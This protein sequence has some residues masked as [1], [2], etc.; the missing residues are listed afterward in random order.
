MSRSD[1]YLRPDSPVL[2]NKA[3]ETSFEALEA[4]KLKYL[5]L[6]LA[7]R[8]ADLI[9]IGKE[10]NYS[11]EHLVE[12]HTALNKGL[13]DFAGKTRDYPVEKKFEHSEHYLA[14]EM[15][16]PVLND[17]YNRLVTHDWFEDR[18]L[19]DQKRYT[20]QFA[21]IMSRTYSELLRA[22]P[23]EA[24]NEL[25]I[26]VFIDQMATD[27]GFDLDWNEI[28]NAAEFKSTSPEAMMKE[29]R[30]EA[31][32]GDTIRLNQ[33]FKHIATPVDYRVN[34][35]LDRSHQKSLM[36]LAQGLRDERAE[37]AQEK[38]FFKNSNVQNYLDARE[39]EVSGRAH[40]D[41]LDP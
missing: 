6:T 4:R 29:L 35:D 33:V 31:I 28:G 19:E 25:A 17:V 38:Q 34:Q 5:R 16:D 41:R 39:I 20:N 40:R 30:D 15:I 36:G 9:E 13:F 27:A 24:E 10:H 18:D 7:A 1:L 21:N 12:L 22:H 8:S 37:Y 26:Q 14:P 2:K 11:K 23:F 3:G 32:R